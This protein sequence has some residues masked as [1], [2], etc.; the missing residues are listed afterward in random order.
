MRTAPIRDITSLALVLLLAACSA[1]DP[2]P[3]TIARALDAGPSPVA[4]A[5]PEPPSTPIPTPPPQPNGTL[6]VWQLDGLSGD[7]ATTESIFKLAL[8]N[9]ATTPI[10]TIP[11]NENTCCPTSVTLSGDRSTAFLYAGNYRGAVDLATGTFAKAGSRIKHGLVA[12]SRAGDRLAWVDDV[13]GTSESI[14][15]A[16]RDGKPLQR[17]ALPAG[18][19]VST[20]TWMSDDAALLVTTMLPLKIASDIRLASTIACCSID[21]GPLATHVLVVPLDGS[22]IRDIYNDSPGVIADQSQ[23]EPT[24]PPGTTAG[25]ASS[26][27]RSLQAWPAPDRRAVAVVAEACPSQWQRRGTDIACTDVLMTIDTESGQRTSLPVPL[28]RISSA[29]W[30]PDGRRLSLLG[31]AGG[32][33]TGLYVLDRASGDLIDLGPAEPELM[34]WSRD[35]A[36]IAYWQLDP[37]V[38]DGGDRVQVWVAPTTGGDARFVAAHASA[39][40][41]EP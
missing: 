19:F 31:S 9:G 27:S 40:W 36:W 34:A 35:G 41:L 15:I 26:A 16:G 17:I 6:L 30:S 13:T 38:P 22:S 4:V 28:T 39:G 14:V 25:F 21:R 11:V 20:P 29:G 3:S 5:S 1:A 18:A 8:A 2:S 23:P 32:G 33:P 24:H 7:T 37:K 12:I 10:A